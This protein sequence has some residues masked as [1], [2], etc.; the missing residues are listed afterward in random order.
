ME[1]FQCR[2]ILNQELNHLLLIGFFILYFFLQLQVLFG[3]LEIARLSY[4]PGLLEHCFS[5][6]PSMD[7]VLIAIETVLAKITIF[8]G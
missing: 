7:A 2:N 5:Q 1:V 3:L 4:S 6:E 8:A